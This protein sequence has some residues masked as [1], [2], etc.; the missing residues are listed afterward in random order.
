M[1][2][3]FLVVFPLFK[4]EFDFAV[5]SLVSSCDSSSSSSYM[6]GLFFVTDL[7]G[8]SSSSSLSLC[9]DDEEG[10]FLFDLL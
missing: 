1:K 3:L 5:L 10:L 8:I 4:A 6:T 2:V 7:F 9:S